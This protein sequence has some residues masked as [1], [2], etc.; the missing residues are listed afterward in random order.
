V[1][2]CVS[3]RVQADSRR[4]ALDAARESLISVSLSSF[5]SS[6]LPSSWRLSS[7]HGPADGVVTGSSSHAAQAICRKKHARGSHYGGRCS[8]GL[9]IDVRISQGAAWETSRRWS[10]TSSRGHGPSASADAWINDSRRRRKSKFQSHRP[11]SL[12]S[13]IPERADRQ[14]MIG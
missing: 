7:V 14:E 4:G 3:T 13:R 5:S 11:S 6:S 10:S 12:D 8:R 9:M 2:T 1:Y